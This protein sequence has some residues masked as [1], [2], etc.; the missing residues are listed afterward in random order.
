SMSFRDVVEIVES[1]RDKIRETLKS[2]GELRFS[3]DLVWYEDESE[4]RSDVIGVDSSYSSRAYKFIYLYIIRSVA[5]PR[6]SDRDL[7]SCVQ[8]DSFGDAH[9]IALPSEETGESRGRTPP[10]VRELKKILSHRARDLEV[11][12][13]YR[14]YECVYRE[15]R[16]KPLILMDGSARSFLPL[17]FKGGERLPQWEELEET[18]R[19]RINILK[20]LS[21]EANIVFISKTQSRTYY[22]QKLTPYIEREDG[23]VSILVPDVILIDLYLAKKK[24]F[25]EGVRTPGFT[26]PVVYK[27]RDPEQDITIF[28]AVFQ[29]GD[30]MFQISMLGNFARDIDLIRSV[31][32]RIRFWSLSGY[33]E[34]LR[35]AHHLSLL[36][37]RDVERLLQLAG[38]YIESGREALEL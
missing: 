5:L 16:E 8:T 4:E 15:S 25:L 38:V 28:Y 35:E 22:S 11:E 27:N 7:R 13:G 12:V 20:D 18:W 24:I 19:R 26:E 6:S 3:G 10:P 32:R 17:R 21:R 9:F 31:Y 2:Y 29:R 34:P 33:P 14:S 23:I 37:Y 1:I 30:G 36:R